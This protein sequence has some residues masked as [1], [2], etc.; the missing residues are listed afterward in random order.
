MVVLHQ[1][2]RALK[3]HLLLASSPSLTSL[4]SKVTKLVWPLSLTNY[5]I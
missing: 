5:V 3:V 1:L 2:D 4:P